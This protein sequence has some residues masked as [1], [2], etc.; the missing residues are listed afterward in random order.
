M[1]FSMNLNQLI[2]YLILSALALSFV[3]VFLFTKKT[4]GLRV[5]KY[6]LKIGL[7][8]QFFAFFIL[9]SVTLF[10]YE[11]VSVNRGF[12]PFSLP[13]GWLGILSYFLIADLFYYLFHRLSHRLNFFWNFHKLH[14]SANAIDWT[15]T[16]RHSLFEMVLRSAL[17][18]ATCLLLNMNI[19]SFYFHLNLIF[20]YQHLMHVEN[21]R[22]SSQLG[23][24][25]ILPQNHRIHHNLTNSHKNY[26]GM[27]SIWDRLFSTY[28]LA[29]TYTKSDY[30]IQDGPDRL[31]LKNW[32]KPL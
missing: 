26:G 14:H 11:F 3:A 15:L 9:T 21:L 1:N 6:N 23:L 13:R 29:D 31:L 30:G 27:L 7:L 24:F 28:Q 18:G 32:I 10:F 16:Y 20:L 25:L 5:K 8:N 12:H 22:W 19:Y 2:F 17:I 4:V